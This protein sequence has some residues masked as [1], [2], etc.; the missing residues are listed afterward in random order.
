MTAFEEKAEAGGIEP[1]ATAGSSGRTVRV[2]DPLVRLFHWSLVAAF[3]IAWTTG[4]ELERLHET[5]GY[6]ILGLLAFRLAWGLVGTR[7]AR[8]GDF[9]YRPSTVV[10]FLVDTVRFRAKRYLGH[11]PAGGA[12]IIALL[13]VLA[14]AT[15]TGTIMTTDAYWG[16]EWVEEAHEV[17]ANLAVVLVGLHLA[18]V[19]IASIEHRE[20]LVRAMI[21]GRKRRE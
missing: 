3:V 6:V 1:P 10:R 5:V 12:M 4:D 18:G 11:N 2:W 8:F 16:V 15:G 14:A 19:F 17:T 9:I 20:N 7:Y 13:I 21:T